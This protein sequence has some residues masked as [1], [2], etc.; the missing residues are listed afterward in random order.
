MV[1]GED[2]STIRAKFGAQNMSSLRNFAVGI[3]HA[4][5]VDNIKRFVDNLKYNTSYFLQAAFGF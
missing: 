1:F 2:R 3:L 4:M 5:G